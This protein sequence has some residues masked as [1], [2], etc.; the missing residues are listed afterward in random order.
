MGP[1]ASELSKLVNSLKGVSARTL[2]KEYESHVRRYLWV[3]HLWSGSRTSP[4]AAAAHR[5]PCP[6]RDGSAVRWKPQPCGQLRR[7]RAGWSRPWLGRR[8]RP[9]PRS[10][11][12]GF[13]GC[14]AIGSCGGPCRDRGEAAPSRALQMVSCQGLPSSAR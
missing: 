11:S 12:G 7:A 10:G 13:S 8:G 3:K 14:T 4:A 1:A 2:R 5:C 6:S 9:A